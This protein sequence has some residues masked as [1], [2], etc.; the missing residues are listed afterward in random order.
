[1]NKRNTSSCTKTSTGFP[2]GVLVFLKSSLKEGVFLYFHSGKL[3]FI[4]D[5]FFDFVNDKNLK[6][7]YET[8]KRPYLFAFR[9]PQTKLLWVVPCSTKVEKYEKII[10]KRKKR[11]K[12]TDYLK[13]ISIFGK[14]QALV[15]QD[16]F[17]ISEKYIAHPYYKKKQHVGIYDPKKIK[18]IEKNARKITRLL[19]NGVLSAPNL[20]NIDKIK[21]LML[22]E[23]EFE[24]VHVLKQKKSIKERIASIEQA[25]TSKQ[26]IQK[27]KRLKQIR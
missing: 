2:V 10:E 8:T 11:N 17:P 16:M 13:I 15:F 3:Y 24:N 9:D 27:H 12:R 23:K 6:M 14:K 5:E 18:E 1:M 22:S 21:N 4:K 25:T 20:P 19:Q 26:K 7:N